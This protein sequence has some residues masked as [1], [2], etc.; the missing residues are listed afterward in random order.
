M[1]LL[2]MRY[3]AAKSE[4]STYP[5][6]S[7]NFSVPYWKPSLCFP[8]EFKDLEPLKPI[9]VTPYVTAGFNQTSE[10]NDAGTNYE[11]NTTPKIDAGLDIKYSFTNNLTTDI[12]INTDFVQVEADNQKINLTRYSLYFPEKR[13]FFLEKADVF[14]FS[15]L[16]G[17]KMFYSRRIGLYQGNPIRIY[18]GIR[19]TGRIGRWDI[20][21]LDM[22]TESFENNPSENFGVLWVKRNVLNSNSF[23]GGMFTSRLGMNGEY[24][25]AYG[26]DGKLR[27]IGDEYLILKWA[28]TFENDSINSINDL[29]YNW[30]GKRYNPGIGFEVKQNYHGPRIILQYGWMPV[31]HHYIRYYKLSLKYVSFYNTPASLHETSS[32]QLRWNFEAKKG[33]SGNIAVNWFLENLQN[34]LVFGKANETI[35]PGKY[36][37]KYINAG[38]YTSG[39][40]AFWTGLYT[41]VGEFFDGW[42]ASFFCNP[43]IKIGTSFDL[44]LTYRYDYINC[45]NRDMYFRN[46][47]V[48][49]K[50]LMTLTTKTSLTAFIQY[51]TA[52]EKIISNIRFR[53]NPREGNDFYF[54]YD[55]GF[56]TILN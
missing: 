46:H 2:L 52:V 38:Y 30:S 20:G 9:Y 24:N 31:D 25:I 14:D 53:Y 51:N 23:V 8:I 40:S 10:L 36:S 47:I 54:V 1:G 21:F 5:V 12:T 11:L 4:I 37:F 39:A 13:V 3:Y 42:K 17:N 45:K 16:D 55:E 28:Q 18:G 29:A 34:E 27:V 26:I 50:E 44:G 41:E 48:G 19:E 6:M 43:E 49:F 35:L 32:G 56:N 15:F 22:Q 7:P 33:F